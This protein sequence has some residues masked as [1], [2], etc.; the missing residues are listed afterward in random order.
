[1]SANNLSFY[2]ARCGTKFTR[3]D[4]FKKHTLK[5]S[6]PSNRCKNKYTELD[7]SVYCK[8]AQAQINY[9]NKHKKK[10]FL[11]NVEPTKEQVTLLA[12]SSDQI[13]AIMRYHMNKEFYQPI[14]N[15]FLNRKIC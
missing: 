1:M 4:V 15:K 3:L 14:I 2:C 5:R 8:N 11:Y 7:W 12:N 9:Y 10:K 6:A 13:H